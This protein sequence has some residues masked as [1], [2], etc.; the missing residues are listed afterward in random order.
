MGIRLLGPVELGTGGGGFVALQGAQ[1]R[2]VLA[3]L[4]LHLGRVV[5]VDAFCELLWD[6]WPPASARAALQGH[7]A[8][9]RKLLAAGP[10]VL[11]TRAPGYLLTGPA[12][13]VDALRFDDL[14][15]RAAAL[16]EATGASAPK[17][18]AALA[19]A[20][21]LLEQAL[22][23]WRGPALADLPDTALRG[24][25]AGQLEQARTAALVSWAALRLRQGTG[26][27]AVPSLEQNVRTNG[28]REEVAAL[29]VR[30]LHQAGRPAD[31]L[32]A[33]HEART[34]LDGELGIRPGPALQAA[35]AEVLADDDGDE[36]GDG[37]GEDD[38][39]ADRRSAQEP[40]PSPAITEAGT[41]V[42]RRLP[43]RPLDFVAREPELHW[44][45]RECGPDRTGD[46]LA[47]VVG[48]AGV[49]KSALALTW[50]H[51]AAA[52]Y[53]DGHL[54]ADL[55]G[56]DPAGPA[57]PGETLGAFLRALG[58]DGPALPADR[59]RRAA[60]YRTLT[61]N[62]RLLVVLDDAAD[63]DQVADLLPHGPGCAAVVTGRG[64]LE[65]LVAAEGAALLRLAPL[66]ASDA[67][68][69]LERVLTPGRVQA[70]AEAATRLA[71]LCDHL[72]LALRIASARLAARP[73]WTIAAL[74]ADLADE[75]TR[76]AVL[77]G[78]GTLG[79]SGELLRTHRQLSPDAAELLTVLAAHPAGEVDVLASAALLGAE[80][81]TARRAL[82]ELTAH[83]LLTGTPHGRYGRSG[84]VRLFSAELLGR[85]PAADRQIAAERLLDYYVEASRACAEHLEPGQETYG[86]SVHHPPALPSPAGPRAAIDWFRAEEP[87]V[88]A[89]VASA[90][91]SDPA[92]AWRLAAA[93]E[94]QYYAAGLF[95]E[96][97]SCMTAGREAA[98]RCGDRVG[99]ARI[100]VAQASA[101]LG[102]RRYQEAVERGRKALAGTRPEDGAVHLR[103]L[104][105]LAVSKALVGRAEEATALTAA[106]LAFATG[107]GEPHRLSATL[108]HG[109]Q[110]SLLVG[111]RAGA[112]RQAREA[113][114]LL[115]GS[116]VTICHLWSM[117]TEAHALQPVADEEA[118]EIAWRRALAACEEAGLLHLLALAEQSYASFLAG[119]G[120]ALEAV[121]RLRSAL[122]RFRADGR[123]PSSMGG[124][125]TAIED[126]LD[127]LTHRHP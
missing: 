36:A 71:A 109:S 47:L 112:L 120:R 97:L 90:G 68:R 96:W 119:H 63:A 122:D 91:R 45:D 48:P 12:E 7:V 44:L 126:Q 83:H 116:T 5:G 99:T 6:D 9:L 58:V 66:P 23:L 89:L 123:L 61:R 2:A 34:R 54:H 55:R 92:R 64:P 4:A 79:V 37:A 70:E 113:R 74:V 94:P 32:R 13:L 40:P 117:L 111:D 20:I 124:F 19:E 81:A 27:A 21:A 108:A 28:L 33:Y 105:A 18:G 62:L 77:E 41:P 85:R 50:A 87:T 93:S 115:P 95:T 125:V 42:P 35:L 67:L 24:T 53:P 15:A 60:L 80:P 86:G 118:C 31:A 25:V 30:C 1:R 56:L 101:L 110:V 59:A 16:A 82:G 104:N 51:T 17:A 22:R 73:D 49:G 72:P 127:A 88:R 38:A 102:L 57:D 8:A 107:T 98:E 65:G 69:L 52:G 78:D 11:H 43:R 84:L 100:G 114:N 106:A 121:G 46:G 3:L 29:L 103:A 75:S 26:A 14:A 10:F 39:S 76:L